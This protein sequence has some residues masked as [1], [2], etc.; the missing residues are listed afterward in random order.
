MIAWCKSRAFSK[1]R[2]PKFSGHLRELERMEVKQLLEQIQQH[3]QVWRKERDQEGVQ[4]TEHH[5]GE[6]FSS[7]MYEQAQTLQGDAMALQELVRSIY[8]LEAQARA[9]CK[10]DEYKQIFANIQGLQ[11]P[12]RTRQLTKLMTDLECNYNIP[13]LRNEVYNQQHK[14]VMELY[15]AVSAARYI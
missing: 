14:D 3:Y 8:E 12:L 5:V 6:Y 4:T 7:W 13:M 9:V 1:K 2:S 11:E 10:L 15:K